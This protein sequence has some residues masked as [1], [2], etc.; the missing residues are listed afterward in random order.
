MGSALSA[1]EETL[2][3]RALH[4]ARDTRFPVVEPGARH[5]AARVF[6]A[7][8]GDGAAVIVADDRTDGAAGRT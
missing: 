7:A 8:F 4:A 2:L 1:E 3:D 5:D 6:A